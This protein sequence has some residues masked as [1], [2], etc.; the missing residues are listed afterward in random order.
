MR[1]LLIL[2]GGTIC[3]KLNKDG[4]KS[5][6]ENAGTL[7]TENFYNSN[8]VYANKVDIK[9]SE[10]LNILSENM[11]IE[12][13]NEIIRVYRKEVAN[14]NFDGIIF[15]HGTDT[16][17]Y[18]A[19]L[20]SMILSGTKIPVFFVSANDRLQSQ[21]SNG[22]AN[23]KCAVECICRKIPANVYAVYENVSDKQ[24][25]LHLASRL[26]Q[27]KIYS[28]DFT[29]VGAINI[30]DISNKNYKDIFAKINIMY[31]PQ[32][33][34]TGIDIF[35]DWTLS[36]CVLMIFPYVGINYESFNYD[37]YSA[38][39]HGTYHS[40]T[41]CCEKTKDNSHYS[42]DS[43]LAMI[44]ACAKSKRKTDAFI[45]PAILKGEIYE[46]SDIIAK[47]EA[48][49]KKINFVYGYTMETTYAKLLLA[50]SIFENTN[51]RMNYIYNEQNFEIIHA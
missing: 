13:L 50:Y 7:L 46:T 15:A 28:E 34:K 35:A 4:T 47:H 18:S 23:F 11:T 37:K 45:A 36:Q 12:N 43:I 3:C 9:L 44:D 33:I 19:A 29:S 20:F 10:N 17:A 49:G 16:L 32:K 2:V 38:V 48:N 24:M 31:P 51:E 8:S 25:Y 39:L 5:I 6:D 22:D 41:A 1:I 42:S 27:C 26:E 30:T 40:G 21:K 14:E